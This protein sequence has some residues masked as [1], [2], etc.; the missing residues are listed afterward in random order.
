MTEP[1]NSPQL[2]VVVPVYNANPLL[3]KCLDSI[4]HQSMKDLEIILVN[5]CSPDPLD[6]KIC[7]EYERVDPRIR[8]IEHDKNLGGGGARNTGLRE[9]NAAYIAFIDSDD[10][11]EPNM[12]E[13]L[14]DAVV[15]GNADF[16]Q[17]YFYRHVDSQVEVQ[18]LKPYNNGV[19]KMNSSNS[20]LWNKVFK[21]SLFLD[22]KIFYPNDIASQDVALMSRLLYFVNKAVLVRKPLYHYR[23]D[24]AGSQTS[25]FE[26]LLNDLPQVFAILQGFLVSIGKFESDRVFFEKRVLRSL[27]HHLGRFLKDPETT[28]EQKNVLIKTKLRHSVKYLSLDMKMI[29]DSIQALDVLLKYERQIN[30]IIFWKRL[31]YQIGRLF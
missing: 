15:A 31:K 9:A 13:L 11:I 7:L 30:R 22:H 12:F 1:V 26:K 2:S 23:E 28:I 27:N 8:Y 19:D 4:I 6:R 16:S 25:S 10:W 17:C 21:K 29:P 24:R 18:R 5:D 20:L 14:F 3:R